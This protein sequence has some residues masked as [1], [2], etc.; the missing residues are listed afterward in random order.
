MLNYKNKRV[1][2]IV[3]IRKTLGS[4]ITNAMKYRKQYDR[5]MSSIIQSGSVQESDKQN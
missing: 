4:L 5:E 3:G 2:K 1:N